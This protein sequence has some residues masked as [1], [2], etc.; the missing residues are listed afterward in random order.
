[1]KDKEMMPT[2]AFESVN[3]NLITHDRI[4]IRP[5]Y[6]ELGFNLVSDV[7]GR[8]IVLEKILAALEKIPQNYGLTIWDVYR[9]RAVQKKLFEW[10]RAEIKKNYPAL[11]DEENLLEAQKYMSLPSQI[12]D[13][14]CPPHL[15]GGAIDLTLHDRATGN[16][17]DMGTIFDDCTERAH[18]DYFEH[19][20]DLDAH[21]LLIRNHRRTLRQAMEAA[22]FT[23]YQYEWWHYDIGTILW[24]KAT[25]KE[26]LFGPLF[27]DLEWPLEIESKEQAHDL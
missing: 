25:G 24:Q 8:R 7:Y 16:E 1:M 2:S 19:A 12:G 13:A 18:R 14:Y 27:G 15:S 9:P 21:S 20:T 3:F 17:I 22:G 11:T 6:Y 26:A 5:M 4:K 23:T 10:M